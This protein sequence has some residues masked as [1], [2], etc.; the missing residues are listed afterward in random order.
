VCPTILILSLCIS[1]SAAAPAS[2]QSGCAASPPRRSAPPTA[3][4]ATG[5]PS[6][7]TRIGA[8]DTLRVSPPVDTGR[9]ADPAAF[10]RAGRDHRSRGSITD[11]L[12]AQEILENGLRRFPDHPDLLAELGATLYVQTLYG[13]AERA[14]R[15]LLEIDP[16]R[17]D[18]YYYLGI[19]AYRKWKRVQSYTDYLVTAE[20][21]LRSAAACDFTPEDAYFKL[22]FSRFL[23]G[24]T[25]RALETCEA[26]QSEF[27]TAPEPHL[28]S[29][30]IAYASGDYESC[31]DRFDR[32]L[33]LM[34]DARLRIYN[35]APALLTEQERDAYES[36][37]PPERDETDRWY[38][39]LNDP[40][41]TTELNERRLEHV[42]RVFLSGARYESFTPPI[43]GWDTARGKALV[44]F[45][46]PDLIE[47]TLGGPRPMD[48]RT[49]MWTYLETE[50][51]FVLFFRDEYLNGNYI[52]PMEDPISSWTIREDP[53]LTSQVR[54]AAAVP[55]VLA[56]LAFRDSDTTAAVFLAYAADADSLDRSLSSWDTE[57]F[58]SRT[59]VYLADGRP[60]GFFA[61]ALPA[62]SL[63]RDSRAA[64]SSYV[65]IEE[66]RLPFGSYRA[67]L[68]LEDDHRVTSSVAW[69]DLD[70]A[71]FAGGSLVSSDIALCS[72][73]GA[74]GAAICRAGRVLSLNPGALYAPGE[75]PILYVEIYNLRTRGGRSEYAL[76]YSIRRAERERGL[77]NW[78]RRAAEK[79]G[80]GGSHPPLVISQTFER[81]GTASTAYEE[82]SVGI[83]SLEPGRYEVTVTAV[84]AATGDST[85]VAG[86]FFK[87][88]TGPRGRE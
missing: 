10:L 82:I 38:W 65:A 24:D 52:V 16:R 34:D 31:R 28:L 69:A 19:D 60:L 76:S 4:S 41:P 58:R 87:A 18:A 23:L 5:A 25:L 68:C 35:G 33:S 29:G 20:R 51:P 37:Q 3:T 7:A 46:E 6:P 9:S 84:D 74:G 72:A 67:A 48:G 83:A 49:E 42:Y 22:A 45:G 66:L 11:R 85:S 79:T 81:V 86:R 55:C 2:S 54:E 88:R 64:A 59:A 73:P 39:V 63:E 75:D 80:I 56:G 26:Y 17:C 8:A 77:W 40:D 15:R 62:D 44:K 47:T 1:L 57:I 70:F 61:R 78:L 43:P 13:D 50:Q 30:A 71:R 53:P 12:R 27:P 36:S 14:F 32:A 21:F